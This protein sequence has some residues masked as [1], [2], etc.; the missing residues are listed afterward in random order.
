M[1][2]WKRLADIFLEV[3]IAVVLVTA[4][5][6]YVARHPRGSPNWGRIALAGNTVVVFGFLISWF[7]QAWKRLVFWTT[8]VVLLLGHTAAYVL[9]L[10]RI[11]DFPLAYY[12]VLNSM[13]LALFTVIL[14]KVI[15]G[16]RD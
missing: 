8:L 4:G 1:K 7:R 10:S 2:R 11:H 14:R 6:V 12:V 5:I 9:V 15:T 13:E 16:N 3:V